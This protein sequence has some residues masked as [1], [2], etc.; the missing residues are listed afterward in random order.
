[1]N[2]PYMAGAAADAADDFTRDLMM[3]MDSER[4]ASLKQ[5]V[6]ATSMLR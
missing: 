3:A 1:M 2:M 5:Q 4:L 6:C